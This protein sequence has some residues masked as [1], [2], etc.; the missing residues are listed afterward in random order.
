[1]FQ[2]DGAQMARAGWF[3]VAQTWVEGERTTWILLAGILGL[4][5]LILPGVA[6]I[7]YWAIYR[8]PGMLT[9]TYQYFG[10][11]GSAT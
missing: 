2:I 6:A 1:M 9:V 3:P 7:I 8:G 4:F 10:Q 11:S 5:L